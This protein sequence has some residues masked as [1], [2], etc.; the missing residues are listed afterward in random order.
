MFMSDPNARAGAAY[1]ALAKGAGGAASGPSGYQ[2]PNYVASNH[3]ASNYVASNYVASNHVA[4]NYGADP[5]S[6]K[7]KGSKASSIASTLGLV[8]FVGICAVVY[9]FLPRKQKVTATPI[10]VPS[11]TM[12]NFV[13]PKGSLPSAKLSSRFDHVKQGKSSAS[14]FWIGSY[15]NTGDAPIARPSARVSLFDAAGARVGEFPGYA[16]RDILA[17]GASFPILVLASSAPAFSRMEIAAGDPSA[18][19]AGQQEVELTVKEFRVAA[20]N[21]GTTD[22][23]GTVKNVSATALQFPKVVAIGRNAAGEAVSIA[24]TFASSKTIASNGESG[25]TVSVGVFQTEKPTRYEVVAFG[26]P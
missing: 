8:A 19:Y 22:L 9:A 11:I 17:P 2:P 4:P 20:T 6:G 5:T 23:V 24:N 12:P 1:G 14:L 3:V 25:F 10:T 16:D 21:Y 13:P 18:T 7:K 15:T 26:R